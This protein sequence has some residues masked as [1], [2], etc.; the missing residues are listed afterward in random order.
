MAALLDRRACCQA[1][2]AFWETL[3]EADQRIVLLRWNREPPVPY[4]AIAQH[5]GQGWTA[6]TIRQRHCR[7]LQRTRVH[8]QGLGLLGGA[9]ADRETPSA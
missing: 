3:G 8:L 9:D 5:L 2:W 4:E 1:I 7:L 6:Q